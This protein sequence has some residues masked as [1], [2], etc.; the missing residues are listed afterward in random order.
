[1][2]IKRFALSSLNYTIA[3]AININIKTKNSSYSHIST[4]FLDTLRI[5]IC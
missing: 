2:E 5:Y 4:L 1:M 3:E